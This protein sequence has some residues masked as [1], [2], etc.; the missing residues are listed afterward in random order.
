MKK[1][2]ILVVLGGIFLVIGL[3]IALGSSANLSKDSTFTITSGTAYYYV[4]TLSGLFAGEQVTF[5]FALQSG[6]TVDVYLLNA[7]AYSS[8]SYDLSVPT[9]LY[10]NPGAVSGSG[11]VV[12]P[13]DGTYYLVLN[14]GSGSS[15]SAQSGTMSIQATGLNVTV[16]AT[17]VTLAVVG[18]ALLALGYR[19]RA[20]EHPAPPGYV[21]PTQVTM[22]PSATALPPPPE[23]PEQG[24]PPPGS[25]PPS[26]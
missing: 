17:G 15:G 25:A 21:A 23:Q 5:S 1:F 11:S 6:G 7:A 22:F 9:S 14:H 16:L 4:Y 26:G 24:P 10:A 20:V 18:I 2:R 3:L 19:M 8:Y 12:I 13:A